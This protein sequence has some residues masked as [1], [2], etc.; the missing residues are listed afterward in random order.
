MLVALWIFETP[1]LKQKVLKLI[2][3]IK[4]PDVIYVIKWTRPSPSVLRPQEESVET[5]MVIKW[6]KSA[7]L[8]ITHYFEAEVNYWFQNPQLILDCV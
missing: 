6:E 3:T 7:A 8:I 1:A 5:F 2:F 4:N